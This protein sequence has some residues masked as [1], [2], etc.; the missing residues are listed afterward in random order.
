MKRH[1][2]QIENYYTQRCDRVDPR[3]NRKAEYYSTQY[4][5]KYNAKSCVLKK[6]T[7]NIAI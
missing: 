6:Y 4:R 3:I 7:C 2:M 1:Q 5:T